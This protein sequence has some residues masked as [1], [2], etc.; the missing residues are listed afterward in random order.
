M[1]RQLSPEDT[2]LYEDKSKELV[3]DMLFRSPVLIPDLSSNYILTF[4]EH[5]NVLLDEAAMLQLFVVTVFEGIM[6]G[7]QLETQQLSC[8]Q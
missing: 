8:P 2:K 1:A 5:R 3:S 4:T 7:W 6:F